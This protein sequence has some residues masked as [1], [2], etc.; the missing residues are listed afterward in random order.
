MFA[1]LADL[2]KEVQ[3]QLNDPNWH[4]SIEKLAHP[5]LFERFLQLAEP[6]SPIT[7]AKTSRYGGKTRDDVYIVPKARRILDLEREYQRVRSSES[8]GTYADPHICAASKSALR[9]RRGSRIGAPA[10]KLIHDALDEVG[11]ATTQPTIP[12]VM[13]TVW[14]KFAAENAERRKDGL[15]DLPRPSAKVVRDIRATQ[16]GRTLKEVAEKGATWAYN[17]CSRGST[18]VRAL[19]IG[20]FVQIDSCKVSLVAIYKRERLWRLLSQEEKDQF[21]KIDEHLDRFFILI[22][23]DVASRMPLGWVVTETPTAS[24]AMQV[25]RMATRSKE[26]ECRVCGCESEAIGA[27]GI[28]A[29][30][31]DNGSEF[32]NG[33][34]KQALLGNLITSIDARAGVGTDKAFIEVSFKTLQESLFRALPGFTGHKP[35]AL[36]GYDA[37]KNAALTLEKVLELVTRYLVDEYPFRRHYG[38]GMF[39]HTPM[40]VYE[41]INANRGTVTP[42]DPNMRREFLGRMYEVT[43]SDEGVRLLGGALWFNEFKEFQKRL[44]THRGKIRVF[45]D[46]DDGSYAT[47]IFDGDPRRYVLHQQ[48]SHFYGLSLAE[49]VDFIGKIR[50][51]F[52]DSSELHDELFRKAAMRRAKDSKDVCL[53][54]GVNRGERG[55]QQV[56]AEARKIMSGRRYVHEPARADVSPPG[57]IGMPDEMPVRSSSSRAMDLTPVPAVEAQVAPETSPDKMPAPTRIPPKEKA[58]PVQ[59]GPKDR[60]FGR[61]ASTANIVANPKEKKS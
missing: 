38:T 12:N 46:P 57:T 7:L 15:G 4:L 27:V 18:N 23:I 55:F 11:H 44:E 37:V 45:I 53:E 31:G 16:W 6:Y 24:A 60:R 51:E 35:G 59:T 14:A 3:E 25:L 49:V 28:S 13:P 2:R 29:L 52:P 10:L 30:V 42:I 20:E 56:E 54:N 34:V 1:G 47:A 22:A 5:A 58:E 9:G 36:P 33:E 26:K 32:R 41:W 50:R 39:G 21:K 48:M 43:P 40:Q 19:F 61:T 8:D 17:N